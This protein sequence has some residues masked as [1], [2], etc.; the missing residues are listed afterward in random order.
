MQRVQSVP[1]N[2]QKT[3]TPRDKKH[4]PKRHAVHTPKV[5][6]AVLLEHS[7]KNTTVQPKGT[8]TDRTYTSLR[9]QPTRYVLLPQKLKNRANR[10]E[11][12]TR[13]IAEKTDRKTIDDAAKPTRVTLHR[14]R[15]ARHPSWHKVT[16][17]DEAFKQAALACLPNTDPLPK[18]TRSAKSGSAESIFSPIN[19]LRKQIS[20]P[21]L[22]NINVS[23][24]LHRIVESALKACAPPK[25]LATENRK[26]N[27][28]T[29][30]CVT[31]RSGYRKCPCIAPSLSARICRRSQT[32]RSTCPTRTQR[33]CLCP[34]WTSNR[35]RAQHDD[36]TRGKGGWE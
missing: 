31:H 26:K 13:R 8:K 33:K 18:K 12:S 32:P 28:H 25:Q 29:H 17:M 34:C 4:P 1:Q 5:G 6:T 7:T 22:H 30:E 21:K 16:C 36:N 35:G 14:P 20:R 15:G 3:P 23:V 11:S 10:E 24:F 9:L 27:T 2:Q 19:L